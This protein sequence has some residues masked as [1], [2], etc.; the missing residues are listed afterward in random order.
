MIGLMWV[1]PFIYPYHEYPLT[2]FYQEWLTVILGLAAATV[3]L[4]KREQIVVPAVAMMPVGLTA[5]VAVQGAG[6]LPVVYFA[7][8]GV[9]MALGASL[10]A[11]VSIERLAVALVIGAELNALIGVLQY[12]D[13]RTVLDAYINQRPSIGV[14]G[15]IGQRNHY[16][17][18]LA[19]GLAS[20]A[21][22][23]IRARY[24]MLLAAPILFALALSGSRSGVLY[25]GVVALFVWRGQGWPVPVLAAVTVIAALALGQQWET[26]ARLTNG[27]DMFGIRFYLWREAW[28][29]F[30][31]HPWFGVGFGQF[32]WH[33][34]TLGPYFHD[35]SITGLYNNAHNIVAQIAAEMGVAGLLAV[36]VPLVLWVRAVRRNRWGFLLLAVLAIHS[37]LE[38]PLWYAYFIG[39]AGFVFGMMDGRTVTVNR[40]V[41]ACIVG[42]AWAVALTT[43]AGYRGGQA[44]PV[45]T[46]YLRAYTAAPSL[47]ENE[48]T[49]HVLPTQTAAYRQVAWLVIAGREDDAR[50]QIERCL[51]AYPEYYPTMI[52]YLDPPLREFALSRWAE[53]RASE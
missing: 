45:L 1:L 25:V 23:P 46:Q 43:F 40:W 8:I 36:A 50:V 49:M 53:R 44:P 26:V 4:F 21:F 19:L 39:I 48:A 47:A 41:A 51:W 33:H 20:V 6:V 18:Y 42:A 22:L 24:A 38:Y 3:L 12:Y 17:T 34:F 14:Y 35:T 16:A 15:N 2:T 52:R 31:Q 30:E 13:V 28:L 5:V 32:A 27:S 7:W 37:M 10:G 29:M 9:A 11:T